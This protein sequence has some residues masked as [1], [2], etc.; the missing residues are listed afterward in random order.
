MIYTLYNDIVYRP[1]LNLLILFY[2][3]IPGHDMGV[4]IIVLTVLI[5]LLLAPSFHKSLKSQ[6]AMNDL[7][8]KLNEV[9]E[10]YKDDKEAQARAMMDLYK[11]HNVNP[12]SSCL[13]LLIQLPILIALVWVFRAGVGGGEIA[14]LYGFV[15]AP[16]YINPTFLHL[17]DLSKVAVTGGHWYLIDANWYWPAAILAILAGAVQ[18]WQS[19]LMMPK[20][21][22]GQDPNM[23]AMNMQMMYLM[24]LFSFYIT[25]R[26]PAALGLYWVVTTLFAVAQQYYILRKPKPVSQ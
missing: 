14:G 4:V 20:N 11:Q 19:K 7:Q 3:I 1:L 5:R 17:V 12:L 6:K 21:G 2:N 13:P 8:P 24:P 16:A 25:L 15:H 23:R 9:R 26:F 18:F 22:A 10:K